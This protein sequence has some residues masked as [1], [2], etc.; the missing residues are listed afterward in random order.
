M[1]SQ[2]R[3]RALRGL[4]EASAS[5]ISSLDLA[6]TLDSVASAIVAGLGFEIAVVNLVVDDDQVE[7]V[8]VA[9]SD[10][11]RE[12]LLGSRQSMADW[13][14]MLELAQPW[15]ELRFVHHDAMAAAS[16]DW[17]L[18]VP[19]LPVSDDPNAWHPYD[20]LFA[21]LSGPDGALV[22]VLSVDLPVDRRIPGA[23]QR[24]LLELFAAQA[25]AAI[26]NARMYG[27]LVESESRLAERLQQVR[28]S[29]ER[30]RVI[31]KTSPVGM[32]LFDD[33]GVFREVNEAYQRFLGRPAEDILGHR[34]LE[35]THPDDVGET[36]AAS[37]VVRASPGVVRRVEKRY[38]HADGSLR[39][40]RLSLSAF[41]ASDGKSWVLA[42]VEDITESRRTREELRHLAHHD[43]LTGLPNRTVLL[44]AATRALATASVA[45]PVSVLFVD[46]DRFK[47]VNDSF[48]HRT[49]DAVLRSIADRLSRSIRAGDMAGRLGGDEF[50]VVSSLPAPAA[51][52][53]ADRLRSALSEEVM[54]N[55]C[56]V[57]VS[58]SVGVTTID[59]P[60]QDAEAA[61][62]VADQAMYASKL[63]GGDR[64]TVFDDIVR[65]AV[66]SRR[67]T[68]A[69]LREVLDGRGT[70]RVDY[71]PIVDLDSG[72]QVG[73]E[74]LVRLVDAA[75]SLHYPDSFID[76]AEESGLIVALGRRVLQIACRHAA[77]L[78]PLGDREFVLAVNVS[79]QQASRTD[80]TTTVLE[81]LDECGLPASRLSLEL[82]ESALLHSGPGV[83]DHLQR[84]R[85]AGIGLGVDDFGTGYASLT[86]LQQLPVTFVKVDR[87]FTAGLPTD[88][89]AS[90]IVNSVIG[91]AGN[92]GLQCVVEGIER[93]DQLAALTGRGILGQGFLFGRP[94]PTG[95][96][97]LTAVI[98]D[99]GGRPRDGAAVPAG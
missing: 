65:Q 71:Q 32:A 26:A 22:G 96:T 8:A 92:L 11:E 34:V 80:F 3:S 47:R 97:D 42:Q 63:V 75:G 6:E 61:V 77:Q 76:I 99:R 16:P 56:A 9:G 51:S 39:W 4:H 7:V 12:A 60:G 53:L 59:A 41:D 50:A 21:P 98:R 81:T 89:G 73:A 37:A 87:S 84:L 88:A 1:D 38:R 5:V 82:T 36:T 54:V 18:W 93:E 15:G 45:T 66:R 68:E 33:G 46:V 64:V 94:S 48:G 85:A 52:A 55:G 49:G 35:F 74:A 2:Q 13:L 62:A 78:R 17:Q 14:T 69:M 86:Y 40:G 43:P 31:F 23:V 58:V 19:D 20:A 25:A 57:S 28:R 44:A 72:R 30:F 79:A 70:V 91:L 29:E 67:E 83:V 90:A 27:R 24:E 10:E 95:L